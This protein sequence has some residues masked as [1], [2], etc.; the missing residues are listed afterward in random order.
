MFRNFTNDFFDKLQAKAMLENCDFP[1]IVKK[2][3]IFAL[4]DQKQRSLLISCSFLSVTVIVV[5]VFILFLEL[6]I[7]VLAFHSL[8]LFHFNYFTRF[9]NII[10]IFIIFLLFI[11][12]QSP[13][14]SLFIFAV[15]VF[16][17]FLLIFLYI[18]LILVSIFK[19]KSVFSSFT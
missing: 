6:F 14:T 17:I 19:F 10:F 18:V 4:L 16:L 9:F 11:L 8:L 12:F 15:L 13:L 5:V 2:V 7:Y 3:K 1:C